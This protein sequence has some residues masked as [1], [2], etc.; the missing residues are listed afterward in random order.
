MGL[1]EIIARE[2]ARAGTGRAHTARTAIIA[3]DAGQLGQDLSGQTGAEALLVEQVVLALLAAIQGAA[4]HAAGLA[5]QTLESLHEEPH[6]TEAGVHGR[7]EP[8]VGL[9]GLTVIYSTAAGGTSNRTPYAQA[10]HLDSA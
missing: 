6:W 3:V 9:A 1:S 8:E 5:D 10:E 4:A 7:V 2:A